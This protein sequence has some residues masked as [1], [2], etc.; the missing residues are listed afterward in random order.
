M[1]AMLGTGKDSCC[2][3]AHIKWEEE[4]TVRSKKNTMGAGRGPTP[5]HSLSI[6]NSPAN[7]TKRV[8]EY[9]FSTYP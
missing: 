4:R 3:H 6:K 2:K 1:R 8:V 5:S 9:R 7:P